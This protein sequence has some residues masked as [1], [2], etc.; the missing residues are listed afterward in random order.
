MLRKHRK[1]ILSVLIVGLLLWGIS[2]FFPAPRLSKITKEKVR[3]EYF[4]QF[5]GGYEGDYLQRPI[6]WYDENWYR[7]EKNVWRYLGKYGDCYAFLG[8]GD[9][10][11]LVGLPTQDPFPIEGL[12]RTV[13]Y[14]REAYVYLYH[15][16]KEFIYSSGEP[17]RMQVLSGLAHKREEWLTDE[18]LEQLTRYIE[19]LAKDYN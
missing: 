4:D 15:T 12:T 13:Y 10:K 7:E 11:D 9:N 17:R 1:I 19:K 18:Q 6:I 16:K 2:F 8:I 3:T 14:H 5:C